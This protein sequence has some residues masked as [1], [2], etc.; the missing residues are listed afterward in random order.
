MSYSI[1][2]IAAYLVPM[3]YILIDQR[4]VIKHEGLYKSIVVFIPLLNLIFMVGFIIMEVDY[5]IRK[6][7]NKKRKL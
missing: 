1:L 3:V 5:I 4:K 6:L 7:K 2:I